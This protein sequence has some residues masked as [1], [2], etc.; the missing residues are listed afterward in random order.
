MCHLFAAAE[1]A[2][3]RS[4]KRRRVNDKL[5]LKLKCGACGGKGHMRT[6]KAC[7]KYVPGE[8]DDPNSFTEKEDEDTIEKEMVSGLNPI[9]A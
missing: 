9:D 3:A 4:N 7:P 6:N 2:L 5:D 1:L 8:F